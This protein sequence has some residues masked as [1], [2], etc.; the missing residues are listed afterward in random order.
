MAAVDALGDVWEPDSAAVLLDHVPLTHPDAR[1]RLALVRALPG[2]A[3]VAGGALTGRVVDALVALT[4]DEEP[5]VRD[6][7]AFGL[8]QVEADTPAVRD[9]L[10]VLLDDRDPDVR[11]EAMLALAST[12]DDRARTALLARL[13]SGTNL[14]LLELE[15]AVV[16]ADPALH[17]ELLRLAED[18]AGDDDEFTPLLDAALARSRPG[19]AD[20]A[21]AAEVA[22]VGAVRRAVPGLALLELRGAYPRT[23]LLAAREPGDAPVLVPLWARGEDPGADRR[24]SAV[25]A[26]VEGLRPPSP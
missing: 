16:L 23:V 21:H 10:V 20:D 2:G 1:I 22:V 17:A 15:A 7:A 26:V 18:W 8:A 11:S 6:W 3:V 19:A 9:A 24:E 25:T 14:T 12:G 4:R 5:R 13:G